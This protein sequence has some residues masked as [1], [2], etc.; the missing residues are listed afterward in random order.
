MSDRTIVIA[1]HTPLLQVITNEA[2]EAK[3][4]RLA[5]RIVV[6]DSD[7]PWTK[8]ELVAHLDGDVRGLITCWHSPAVD[9]EVLDVAPNLEIIGHS[10][11]SVR[12]LLD[13][14]VWARGVR[15]THAAAVIGEAVAEYTLAVILAGLRRI[16]S[17][18]RRLHVGA[19]W[20]DEFEGQWGRTLHGKRV[21][22]VGASRVGRALVPLLKP[23]TPD[24]VLYDPYLTPEDARQL[25]V[26]RVE[27]DELLSGSDVVTIHAPAI[28]ETRHMIGAVQFARMKPRALLVNSARSWV[29]DQ[30]A[31][32]D[33]LLSD[34]IEAALDVFDQEPLP[35]D[36]PFRAL[37]NVILTPHIAGLTV[38]HRQRQLE[39]VADEFER[40]F[41][42][43]PLVHEIRLEDLDR[44]A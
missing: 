36:S 3:I 44:L 23:F 27:L 12:H 30:Q 22:I 1:V 8:A 37:P 33:A 32:L 4:R 24:I 20:R 35:D 14:Q 40:H 10:A 2:A 43:E 11:G 31:M 7:Q 39:L 29:V 17:Y 16:V 19:G 15:V 5:D 18:N 26:A 25:G 42:G 38:E 41:G 6:V 21:G 9:A 34:R 28:P 13:R